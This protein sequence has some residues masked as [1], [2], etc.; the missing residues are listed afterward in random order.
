MAG[1]EQISCP[2]CEKVD[3]K[4]VGLTPQGKQRYYCCNNTDCKKKTFLNNYQ[5]NARKPGVTQQIIAMA[6]NGSGIRDTSR[7]LGV[8]KTTVIKTLK[9]ACDL[10]TSHPGYSS[11][12]SPNGSSLTVSLGRCRLEAELDEQW[13]YV[14]SKQHP[15][16]IWY[17]IDHTTNTILSYTFGRRK[18]SVFKTLKK[19]LAPFNISHY[20]TDD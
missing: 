14:G 11:N 12:K 9:K 15:H 1:Y 7:V 17:A 10:V 18:D 2:A 5:Y 8:S 4:K 13:S 16:W 20:Y 19:Q 3:I 6:I